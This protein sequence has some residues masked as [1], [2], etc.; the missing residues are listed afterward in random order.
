MGKSLG[1]SIFIHNGIEFDYCLEASASSLAACCD[2]VVILDASSTDG[3]TEWAIEIGK[4]F[5]NVQVITGIPWEQASNY[6]RLA[7]LANIAKSYLRTEWHFMLQAD[8][9]LHESSFSHIRDVMERPNCRS[10]FVRRLNFFGDTDHFIKIEQEGCHK[11]CG[12]TIVRLATLDNPAVGDAESLG[13]DPAY[14]T[15]QYLDKITIFHYGYIRRD[16]N[17]IKKTISMQSWFWGPDSQPDQRVVEMDKKGD[18]IYDWRTMKNPS[19]FSRLPYLGIGHPRFAQ[20]YIN[21]RKLDKTIP[22]IEG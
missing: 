17:H 10:A 16:T 7:K 21:D 6:E 22:V 15:D 4:K 13:V 1:G 12:D 14:I 9:V 5:G 2:E 20:E 11:P 18:G 3:T 8:E 19:Q